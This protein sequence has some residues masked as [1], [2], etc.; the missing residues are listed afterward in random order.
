MIAQE[1]Q[2]KLRER[3]EK[4]KALNIENTRLIQINCRNEQ[5]IKALKHEIRQLLHRTPIVNKMCTRKKPYRTL[6]EVEEVITRFGGRGYE[7]PLCFCFHH[8][9]KEM[10]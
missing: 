5:I 8:T 4:I 6:Q 2:E 7:C 10:K 9:T 1:M 3:N